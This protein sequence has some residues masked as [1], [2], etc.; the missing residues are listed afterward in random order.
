[1]GYEAKIITDSI[2]LSSHR[3]TTFEITYPKFVHNELMTHR[4]FSRNT[5]SSRAIPY[6]KTRDQVMTDPVLPVWWGKNQAGMQAKEELDEVTRGHAEYQWLVARD[7]AIFRADELNRLGAHKQIVNR[8]IEPW[9]W[10]TAIVT[11]TNYDN[12]FHLRCHSEAQP[13]I[14]K[15]AFM[16]RDLYYNHCPNM[17]FEGQW[18]LPYILDD[19]IHEVSFT[20]GVTLKDAFISQ[21]QALRDIN[22]I[23]CKISTARCG[24]VSYLTQNG[25]RDHREDIGLFA[26]LKTSGHWS[27]FEHVATPMSELKG[28]DV[29]VNWQSGNF[30]GWHQFRKEFPTEYCTNY[31]WEEN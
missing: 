13:E 27:P 26:K 22:E 1:M 12:F 29:R 31:V 24:R 15:I 7:E 21:S 14:Q 11:S 20:S 19:D 8:V 18:H 6:K 28:D 4:M 10:I 17:L 3:L 5:A 25:V 30:T 9:M 2:S 16:M 23:L